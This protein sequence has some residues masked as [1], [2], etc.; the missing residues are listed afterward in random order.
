MKNR[1]SRGF[2]LIETIMVLAIV[3]AL[4]ALAFAALGPAR[5]AGRRSGCMSNLHQWGHAFSLYSADWDGQEPIQGQ[6]MLHAQLGLPE[7]AQ[8]F[9]FVKAYHLNDSPVAFCP[10]AHYSPAQKRKS[11]RISSY[12]ITAIV[13]ET[14]DPDM[15]ERI[16]R[17]GPAYPLLVCDMHNGDTDWLDQPTWAHK[18]IQV[19]LINQQVIY[20]NVPVQTG[21]F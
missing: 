20:K 19:L 6:P 2:T 16:S 13:P 1:T 11:G 14:V 7:G 3:A 9:T 4:S 21:D 5:E 18:N 15:P 17:L 8:I 10:S 12:H